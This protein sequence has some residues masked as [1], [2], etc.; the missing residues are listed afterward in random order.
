LTQQECDDTI[1]DIWAYLKPK[2]ISR[3]DPST[4]ESW[5]QTGLASEGIVG[6]DP[7]F[8]NRAILNRQNPKL[9]KVYSEL[10]GRP[11]LLVN[12]DRYGLFR[13]TRS[14]PIKKKGGGV[15][16]CKKELWKTWANLHLDMNPV[17]YVEEKDS[18]WQ[19]KKLNELQ[20]KRTQDFIVENN[21]VGVLAENQT[22]IQ[23]LINLADNK[24]ED[25]GFHIVPGF[26]HHLHEWVGKNLVEL[27]QRFQKGNNFCVIEE[28]ETAQKLS[29]RVTARAGS[30]VLWDQ[31]TL[32]GSRPNDS[33]RPRYAQFIKMFPAAMDAARAKRRAQCVKQHIDRSGFDEK[34]ITELGR[35][36]FGYEVWPDNSSS[37][38]NSSSNSELKD[39][40]ASNNNTKSSDVKDSKPMDVDK[41]NTSKDSS[42]PNDKTSEQ[43]SGAED[44][45]RMQEDSDNSKQNSGKS[46]KWAKQS[47]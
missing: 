40:N 26:R 43:S 7:I 13:P 8:R 34:Q 5:N 19:V 31:R 3:E 25:G 38:N 9:Y 32:H 18:A 24:E 46:V 2:G 1:Q 30:I 10:Y 20:Y 44:S 35:K 33:K 22:H 21:F 14:V 29:I 27:K 45:N 37:S 11:D 6:H 47:S 36:L 28:G 23:G 15:K 12:H 41:S 17:Q 4:W 16:N 39:S 42:K